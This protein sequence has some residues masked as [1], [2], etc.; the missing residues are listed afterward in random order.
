MASLH[1]AV[2][3]KSED[4]ESI[5]VADTHQPVQKIDPSHTM[6][7]GM[8]HLFNHHFVGVLL[9]IE[10]AMDNLPK[11]GKTFR[12]LTEAMKSA[13]QAAE[14]CRWLM[15][16]LGFC[17]GYGA[18]GRASLSVSE[19]CARFLPVFRAMVPPNTR[20][21]TDLPRCGLS[22]AI[23]PDLLQQ[24]LI[25][26]IQGAG[27]FF[28]GAPTAFYFRVRTVGTETLPDQGLFSSGAG[29]VYACVEIE[30]RGCPPADRGG[31]AVLRTLSASG[32]IL[33]VCGGCVA[34]E[35]KEAGNLTFKILMPARGAEPLPAG[36]KVVSGSISE[37][38]A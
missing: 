37:L 17:L 4:T 20:L 8:T 31:N 6:A 15:G 21:E 29:S 33:S 16:S 11:D 1:H 3:F 14:V 22:V 18:S 36:T 5:D 24:L 27:E 28:G 38:F 34:A 13:C 32:A 2:E 10:M 12:L 30:S 25:N 26:V 23:S 9:N 19:A 7:A 35:N